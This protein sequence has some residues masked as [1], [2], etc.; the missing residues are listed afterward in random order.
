MKKIAFVFFC[1]VGLGSF[2]SAMVPGAGKSLET[3]ATLP[4]T[5]DDGETGFG[6]SFGYLSQTSISPHLYA[7]GDLGI[8]FWGKASSLT[9]ST[10]AVQLLP[11]VVYQ[12]AK[13]ST[14][15]PYV[16]FSTGPYLYVAK[17]VGGAGVDFALFFRP[18][19]NWS[20]GK[21]SGLNFEAKFGSI[22][23]ALV[24]LPTVNFSFQI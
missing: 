23:G 20:F 19:I 4:L 15:T 13:S 3:G 9:D 24:V 1:L 7:G 22:A 14:W 5:P 11:T 16:G 8:H 2:S 17:P 6:F 10:T 21:T 12:V 18:G